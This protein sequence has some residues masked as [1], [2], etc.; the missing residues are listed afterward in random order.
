MAMGETH[1]IRVKLFIPTLILAIFLVNTFSFSISVA[2]LDVAKS[3]DISAGTASQ[4]FNVNRFAGL[5]TG[6]IMS[7]LTVR[8]KL[9]S[10]LLVGVGIYG[11][12]LVG[13][14]LS[15][16]FTTMMFFQFFLGMGGP[17]VIIL[18]Y[19]LIG[20]N[21]PLQKRGWAV[22]L[23]WS[24]AF[25]TSVIAY[26]LAG[27]VVQTFGW[28]QLL[29]LIYFPISIVTLI[30]SFL[31]ISSKSFQEQTPV[32]SEFKRAL[33]ELLSTK[34]TIGCLAAVTSVFFLSTATY[35]VPSFLRTQFS[36]SVAEAGT[37]AAMVG[38]TGIFGALIVGKL[39]NRIGRR[40]IAIWMALIAGTSTMIL[41]LMPNIFTS[42]AIW[43]ISMLSVSM[44]ETTLY[45][46]ALEQSS[47]Y[48][49][50]MMSINQS[51]RYLG[52]VIGLS[53]GGFVLN[54]F[55]N[56]YPLLLGIFG[57]SGIICAAFVLLLAKEPCKV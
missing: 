49:S 31:V 50:S 4:L 41:A 17:A 54:F 18:V 40:P 32:K 9:K 35:Y 7:A 5:I 11:I 42:A 8:F 12:G 30:L 43:G 48:R 13:S 38:A 25:V 51:F 37:Y 2:L 45:S 26:L 52:T 16:D 34:S 21:L 24:T 33:K 39:I 57:I 56:N 14:S 15:I 47:T 1:N 46:L 6:L 29:L 10:L 22:G 27:V 19:A 36:I 28:R 55:G 53:L 3:F 23:M 20:E 44:V